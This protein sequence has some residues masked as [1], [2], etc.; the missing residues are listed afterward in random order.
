MLKELP[1]SEKSLLIV[2]G[3]DE[4]HENKRKVE[5][6]RMTDSLLVEG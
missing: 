2:D 5:L 4:M 1:P 6:L 3:L